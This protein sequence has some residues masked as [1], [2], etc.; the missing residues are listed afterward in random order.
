MALNNLEIGALLN[1][2]K[3]VLYTKSVRKIYEKI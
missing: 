3:N 1:S 2:T